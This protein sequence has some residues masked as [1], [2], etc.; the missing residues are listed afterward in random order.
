MQYLQSIDYTQQKSI[1]YLQRMHHLLKNL[2]LKKFNF[3]YICLLKLINN[4]RNLII[5]INYF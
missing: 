4:K 5:F 3:Y 1:K 2:I